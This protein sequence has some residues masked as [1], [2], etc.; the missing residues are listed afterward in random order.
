[1]RQPEFSRD[2]DG[3]VVTEQGRLDLLTVPTCHC[4]PR[5]EGLLFVCPE[6][7]TVYGS[8]RNSGSLYSMSRDKRR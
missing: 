7:D 2:W 3:Y 4:T 1:M 8:L 6:C 5:L